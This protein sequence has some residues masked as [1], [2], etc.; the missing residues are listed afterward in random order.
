[1]TINEQRQQVRRL[2]NDSSAADAP[3]AYYALFHPPDRSTLFVRTDDS[4]RARGFA[5]VFRT[6]LDL[7]RPLVT[8]CCP[9][10]ECAAGLLAKALTPGRPYIF[11]AALNQL[12]LVGG[13]FEIHHQRTLHIYRLTLSRF[14]P[15]I[16]V[17][18]VRRDTPDG[19]PRCV[20]ESGE[21]KAV[22]GV[23]WQSPGFAEIY[24]HTDAQVRRRGWGLSVA[25]AVTQ[26]VL[27]NTR[28]PLYLVEPDNQPSVELAEKLG[29]VDTGA[30][31]VMADVVYQ[32]PPGGM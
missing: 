5:G 26:A 7:F 6:G 2:I 10:P 11:F 17:L 13:S 3:T 22:A 19:L 18:V 25:S 20:I 12:P 32:G 28:I 16:N 21:M 27:D 30:R 4:G 15:V 23:N 29:Y 24:V 31:Q 14:E 8:M 9:N 1:M